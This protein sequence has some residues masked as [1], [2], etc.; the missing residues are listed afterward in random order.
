MKEP[1]NEYGDFRG[2][3]LAD[4]KEALQGRFPA[5]K[6]NQAKQET[7]ELLTGLQPDSQHHYSSQSFVDQSPYVKQE[8]PPV[9]INRLMSNSS[10][11]LIRRPQTSLST[12]N[13]TI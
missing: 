13:Q 3:L 11:K 12:L 10:S 1:L 8:T 9:H 7:A 6:L 4:Y 5:R 2:L